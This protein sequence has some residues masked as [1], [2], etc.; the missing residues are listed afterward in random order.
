MKKFSTILLLLPSIS[1]LAG[2]GNHALSGSGQIVNRSITVQ[3]TE[4]QHAGNQGVSHIKL[5]C[6]DPKIH[7][8]DISIM[9]ALE[10]FGKG[11]IQ[12]ENEKPGFVISNIGDGKIRVDFTGD[13]DQKINDIDFTVKYIV[14]GNV[15][16]ITGFN[17]T[18]PIKV[19]VINRNDMNL[20]KSG[21][22][23][24]SSQVSSNNI[25]SSNALN[26]Y[27]NPANSTLNVAV[28]VQD[29]SLL[30]IIDLQGKVWS[31]QPIIEPGKISVDVSS[32]PQG[33]YLAEAA[34]P[35]GPVV[36]RFC[37]ER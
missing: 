6:D 33:F 32:L 35:S 1:L 26:L 15:G 16:G 4:E 21:S 8:A 25:G 17:A 12:I 23:D 36:Q 14:E 10:K 3:N 20:I 34:T 28:P 2:G 5:S 9:V 27:P 30:R 19:N 18:A 11:S 22:E 31:S 13:N 7:L 24:I 37:V 29:A